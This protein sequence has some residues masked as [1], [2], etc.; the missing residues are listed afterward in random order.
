MVHEMHFP[1]FTRAGQAAPQLAEAD[2]RT[3]CGRAARVRM[4][5]CIHLRIPGLLGLFSCE[6]HEDAVHELHNSLL[7]ELR[8]VR[9]S[10]RG[11]TGHNTS[12]RKRQGSSMLPTRP[13]GLW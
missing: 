3:L 13:P 12:R 11:H 4:V 9:T 5:K 8:A 6:L 7:D 1:I 10:E 2:A